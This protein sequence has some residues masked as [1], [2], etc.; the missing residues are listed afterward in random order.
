MI[1]SPRQFTGIPLGRYSPAACQQVKAFPA[2]SRELKI[3]GAPQI[4]PGN[5]PHAPHDAFAWEIGV[6]NCGIKAACFALLL[7]VN[8]SVGAFAGTAGI[9][10]QGPT[11]LHLLRLLSLTGLH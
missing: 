10:G 8:P 9:F 4:Y 2:V 11:A 3:P 1:P 7:L 5:V 6:C